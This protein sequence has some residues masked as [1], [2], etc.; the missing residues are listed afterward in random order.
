MMQAGKYYV[1]DLCYVFNT[2][3]WDEICDLIIKGNKCLTGEFEL[4]DGRRFAIY[5]TM[6]GDGLYR[7]QFDN[8]YCVDSGSIGCV[9]VDH[10][11]RKS[12]DEMK[13]LGAIVDMQH[14]FD[15]HCY[16]NGIIKISSTTIDT[17]NDWEY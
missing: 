9:L 5:N 4:K 8:E 17:G 2:Q 13:E 10:T 3:D 7:D 16:D 1:G 6:Y 14:P 11:S 15:T 12:V